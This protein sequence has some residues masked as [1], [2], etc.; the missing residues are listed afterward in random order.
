MVAY[1]AGYR[2]TDKGASFYSS[3]L[4]ASS[5]NESAIRLATKA[6]REEGVEI[7]DCIQILAALGDTYSDLTDSSKNPKFEATQCNKDLLEAAKGRGIITS[8]KPYKENQL[9][10]YHGRK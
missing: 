2:E 3:L 4:V 5:T 10:A 9:R 8:Y 7:S 1:L 6:I